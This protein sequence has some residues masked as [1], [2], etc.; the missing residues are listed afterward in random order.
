MKKLYPLWAAPT[1]QPL[2]YTYAVIVQFC[3]G[4]VHTQILFKTNKLL[5]KKLFSISLLQTTIC[6]HRRHNIKYFHVVHSHDIVYI[7]LGTMHIARIVIKEYLWWC[8]YIQYTSNLNSNFALHTHI[9]YRIS[10]YFTL[11]FFL[12]VQCF[13]LLKFMYFLIF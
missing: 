4:G 2:L 13:C 5:E 9:Y 10:I 1:S 12:L 7:M 3:L 8:M 6:R 11:F